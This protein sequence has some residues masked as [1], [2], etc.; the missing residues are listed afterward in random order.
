MSTSN[1]VLNDLV[2][3]YGFEE[4]I[5]FNVGF[6]PIRLEKDQNFSSPIEKDYFLI[7]NQLWEHKNHIYAMCF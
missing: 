1:S 7:A 6:N 3:T 4:D 2:N 5:I